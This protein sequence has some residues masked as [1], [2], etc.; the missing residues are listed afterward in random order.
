MF[1]HGY[2]HHDYKICLQFREITNEYENYIIM[3]FKLI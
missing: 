2:A 1:E 3:L